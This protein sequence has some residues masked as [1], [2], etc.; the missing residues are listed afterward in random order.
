[1]YEART[2]VNL[3]YDKFGQTKGDELEFLVEKQFF[4]MTFHVRSVTVSALQQ[5]TLS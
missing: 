5:N 3:I 2:G 1:M 4:K